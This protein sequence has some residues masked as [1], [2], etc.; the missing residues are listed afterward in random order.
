MVCD[1]RLLDEEEEA[2][3]TQSLGH[4]T[5]RLVQKYLPLALYSAP[6]LA[7]PCALQRSTAHSARFDGA[8]LSLIS[9]RASRDAQ[10]AL[11]SGGSHSDPRHLHSDTPLNVRQIHVGK[12]LFSPPT[13][14]DIHPHTYVFC[15]P[16]HGQQ[17]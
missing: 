15:I 5:E 9:D 8:L 11:A 13:S 4:C 2:G 16:R 7:F 1:E 10:P 17:G 3:D 14:T 12:Y 6:C